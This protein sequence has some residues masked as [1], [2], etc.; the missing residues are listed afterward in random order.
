MKKYAYFAGK[1]SLCAYLYKHCAKCV[2]EII[3]V[4][5]KKRISIVYSIVNLYSLWSCTERRAV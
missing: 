4:T 5:L 2:G 3:N 1:N